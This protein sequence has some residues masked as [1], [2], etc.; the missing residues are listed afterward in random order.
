MGDLAELVRRIDERLQAVGLTERKASMKATGKAD[1]IRN[2]RRGRSPRIEAVAAIAEVLGVSTAYL[3][4]GTES[5][6]DDDA[7]PQGLTPTVPLAEL[8]VRAHAGAGA[9]VDGERIVAR[10]QVPGDLIR[11]QTSAPHSAIKIITIYGDS[12]EPDL[13][14]GTRVLVD[15]TDCTPS[16]PG[17]FVVF[18]GLGLVCKRVE[19]LPHSDPPRVRLVSDN[20]RYDAREVTLTEAHIQGRVIGRWQWM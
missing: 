11:A 14:A 8:D 10:W 17:V 16:P 6:A 15:T 4:G 13:P 1:T 9:I 7:A 18:D 12:M 5:A 2:I 19:Y 3:Q 20:R